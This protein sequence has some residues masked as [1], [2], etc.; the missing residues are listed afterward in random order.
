MPLN[1]FLL[2]FIMRGENEVLSSVQVVTTS[3]RK[4]VVGPLSVEA[5]SVRSS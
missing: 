4:P 3:D 2:K 5:I 1:S